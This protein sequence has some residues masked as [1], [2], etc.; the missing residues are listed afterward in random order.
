MVF[1]SIQY[2]LYVFHRNTDLFY[3]IYNTINEYNWRQTYNLHL[4]L[5]NH[6]L[7]VVTFQMH[8][9]LFIIIIFNEIKVIVI[10]NWIFYKTDFWGLFMYYIFIFDVL[11]L[12]FFS[13]IFNIIVTPEIINS[14]LFI[15]SFSCSKRF[16]TS[17]S[18]LS[19]ITLFSVFTL[20]RFI[21][22]LITTSFV[23]FLF[24]PISKISYIL[25]YVFFLKTWNFNHYIL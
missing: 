18:T 4:F 13:F 21:I 23:F 15:S 10:F 14:Y 3:N 20:K 16:L 25:N 5:I 6:D 8:Y 2:N 1:L 9:K 11:Y 12:W 17:L 19:L 24:Y 22:P 7:Y